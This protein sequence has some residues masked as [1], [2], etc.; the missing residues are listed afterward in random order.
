[1][2]IIASV[3]D[4]VLFLSA[5]KCFA[6]TSVA[7]N[8][9]AI[10]KNKPKSITEQWSPIFLLKCWMSSLSNKCQVKLRTTFLFVRV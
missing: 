8:R 1:M 2:L 5:A 10:K 9:S 3:I 6:L 7:K 4:L